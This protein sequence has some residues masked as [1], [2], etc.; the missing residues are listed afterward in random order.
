MEEEPNCFSLFSINLYYW[1][2][3]YL[4]RHGSVDEKVG[5][6]QTPP[7]GGSVSFLATSL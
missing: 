1:A 2:W 7:S 3:H 5:D 4:T 6:V